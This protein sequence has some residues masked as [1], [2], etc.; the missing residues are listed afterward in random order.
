M[1]RKHVLFSSFFAICTTSLAL[2]GCGPHPEK[3]KDGGTGTPRSV[4]ITAEEYRFTPSKITARP[5]E[6]LNIALHNKGKM[7]HS[8]EFEVPGQNEAL[9]RNVPPGETGHMSF[10]APSKTGTYTFFSTLGDDRKR[11]L[12]GRLDVEST[13]TKH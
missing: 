3:G 6:Q 9:E 1:T 5:G 4:D 7:E 8:I 12:E 11:G 13:P 10:T 2:A